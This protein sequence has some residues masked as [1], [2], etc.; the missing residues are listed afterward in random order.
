MDAQRDRWHTPLRALALPDRTMRNATLV[1]SILIS[2]LLLGAC[3]EERILPV[4]GNGVVEGREL[5]DDGN[6]EPGDGCDE[7]CMLESRELCD[8]GVDDDGD[9][10]ADCADPDCFSNPLCQGSEVCT[11]GF[12]DD[13]D[14]LVDCA[15]PDCATHFSCQVRERCDNGADDDGD[16]LI[17]CEDGDCSGHPLCGGCDAEIDF[18][19]LAPGESRYLVVDTAEAQGLPA[20]LCAEG[21][22]ALHM[23]FEVAVGFHLRVSAAALSGSLVA[24]LL[25]EEEPG[26]TCETDELLCRAV[27]PPILQIER[28][29]LPP[30]SYRVVLAAAEP[31]ST[32]QVQLGLS[33]I[34][35][36]EE[37]CDNGIDDD[38]DGLVDCDDPGCAGEAGCLVEDCDNGVD[39]DGDN[40]VDCA[41]PDCAQAPPCLPPEDCDNGLDDDG[42]G[43]ADC[44][45]EECAGTAGCLGSDCVVNAD[46]GRLGRG[47]MVSASFDTRLATHDNRASCGGDGPEVVMAFTLDATATVRARL[48][49][50][51]DHVL[52]LG[53][54]AGAGS[55]CDDA[56]YR[57][58]DP[59]GSGRPGDLTV[60]RLGPA[61]YFLWVDAVS[62]QSTGEGSVILEVHP[63]FV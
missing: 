51:G 60:Q 56:E 43:R 52:A 63:P 49:Q 17:D 28:S 18:G 41:D 9:G 34:A 1:P 50:T 32:G 37:I 46:L 20:P 44:A 54:E 45:D 61:R 8:N 11:N 35:G 15:D 59:G 62:S 57:C 7:S 47:A 23:R 6:L 14:G 5:C 29:A 55:W 31:G 19:A 36:T 58:V 2:C 39:D 13:G 25:R 4:C 22:P 12:D 3:G 16:G 38:G 10:S 27:E 33:L 24:A 26:V 53:G 30:G 42:D 40:L 48:H 21:P